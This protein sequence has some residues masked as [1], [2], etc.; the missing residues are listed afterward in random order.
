MARTIVV[1]RRVPHGGGAGGGAAMVRMRLS[2]TAKARIVETAVSGYVGAVNGNER[3]PRRS[4]G[5][6][7]GAASEAEHDRL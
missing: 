7:V 4:L 2:I 5:G 1:N 3:P 6:A